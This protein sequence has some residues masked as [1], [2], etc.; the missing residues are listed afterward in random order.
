MAYP[1]LTRLVKNGF[2]QK[3]KTKGCFE[4][5][6]LKTAFSISPSLEGLDGV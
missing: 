5:Y 1:S 4:D 3:I 2:H 6:Q